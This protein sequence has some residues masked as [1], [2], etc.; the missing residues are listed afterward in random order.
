ML[1]GEELITIIPFLI[2]LEFSYKNLNLSRKRSII[3]AWIV[4]SLL[5]GAIHL[6]TYSWNIIQ[7]ILGIGIVRIIL[8][9]PYI[10]TKNIWTSLL[11]HLLNDWILF[12]PAIFLG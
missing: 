6:P 4:T 5:F 10:K 2:V 3:T 7:A 1:F 12:L 9:Y 11:V 8:T